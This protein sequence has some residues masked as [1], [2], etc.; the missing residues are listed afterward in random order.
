M[1]AA[2]TLAPVSWDRMLRAV[3]KVRDRLL[4]A[5]RALE[6][7]G[8]PYAVAGGN[9]VAAWVSRVD[10]AAVR[11]T[12]DVDILLRRSDLAKA[13]QALEAAGFVYRRVASP[14]QPAGLDV[15]L[16]GPGASVRDAL[17]IVFAGE[18]VRSESVAASPD[19]TESESA[20]AFRVV[21]LEGLV[22]MKLAAWRDKDRTHLR[23]LIEVGLIT[24][25]WP[26]RLPGELGSRLQALLDSP[27]G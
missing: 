13:Q 23:D 18:K 19:V 6:A 5:A 4:R 26:G 11:N 20:G 24:A 12:R 1:R 2:A 10:E 15:F 8:V 14:G 21:T 27:G 16:D 7:G 3:E 9:A 25:E 17:H 22:C